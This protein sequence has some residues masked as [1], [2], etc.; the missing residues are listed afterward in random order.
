MPRHRRHKS[1]PAIYYVMYFILILYIMHLCVKLTT[2][3]NLQR[4]SLLVKK[5]PYILSKQKI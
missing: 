4:K 2:V 5:L 1:K 3:I